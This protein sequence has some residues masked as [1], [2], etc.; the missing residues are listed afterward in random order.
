MSRSNVYASLR[1]ISRKLGTRSVPDLLDL[2]RAGDARPMLTRRGRAAR[3]ARPLHVPGAGH[4][5]DL[6]G[7]GRA[8]TRWRCSCWRRRPGCDVTAVHVDHGLRAGSAARPTSCA[9]AAARFGAALRARAVSTSS[10]ARTSRRAPG[11]A[12]YAVLPPRR[13]DRAHRRRPGR[14]GAAQPAPRRGPRRPARD[15]AADAGRCSAC[16][17]ARRAR[18]ARRSASS[19]STTRRNVDPAIPPQPRPPR[20]AAAARRHRRARRRCRPRPPGRAA[21]DDAALL[22]ELAARARPDRRARAARPRRLPLARRA[23]RAWLRCGSDA[24]HHPPDAATVERVLA[25]ARGRG[26]GH[27]GRRRPARRRARRAAAPRPVRSADVHRAMP[28][29]TRR[30]R[31]ARS[32]SARTSCGRA[33]PSSASRSPPTTRAAR[34]CWSACSR[35]RSCS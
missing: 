22:D 31:S 27:R 26:E 28:R 3:P 15:G 33:S 34:R 1:R 10:R 13:A 25:V 21:R 16:A 11:A 24:E 9:A 6:R 17:G 30:R 14:D 32:S 5:G 29:A 20:A 12:R 4:A 19:R 18:C 7:V 8:P 35:A 23:V 2:V